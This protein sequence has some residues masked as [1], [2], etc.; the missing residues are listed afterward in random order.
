MLQLR[1]RKTSKPLN[2][3]T[4]MVAVEGEIEEKMKVEAT[5]CVDGRSEKMVN[6]NRRSS[7]C[8]MGHS[9][10]DWN[11]ECECGLIHESSRRFS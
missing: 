8:A 3:G 4:V 7:I 9:A 10:N 6:N 5:N 11:P 1:R 2:A